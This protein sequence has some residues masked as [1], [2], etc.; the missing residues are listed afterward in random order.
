[1]KN[2]FLGGGFTGP[3]LLFYNLVLPLALRIKEVTELSHGFRHLSYQFA[4]FN[5]FCRHLASYKPFCSIALSYSNR[6]IPNVTY[7]CPI[8][9]P[10][11]LQENSVPVFFIV[12]LLLPITFVVHTFSCKPL[13]SKHLFQS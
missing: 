8:L 9:L 2:A 6:L 5:V 4:N 11:T 7:L 1:M 3:S 10:H 13:H 12:L